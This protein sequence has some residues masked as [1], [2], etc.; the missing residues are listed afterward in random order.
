MTRRGDR[1]AAHAEPYAPHRRTAVLFAGVGTAGVYHAGVLRALHEAGVKIDVVAGRGIGAVTALFAAVDGSARLWDS[2]G[3]WHAPV[4]PQLYPWHPWLR[5]FGWAS[6]LAVFLVV[7]PIAAIV[8]G[9]IVFPIDFVLRML[10]WSGQGLTEGYVSVV[11]AAFGPT[12]FPTW[13]PRFVVLALGG[14]LALVAASAVV[15]TAR[16]RERGPL[17]W[18]MVPAPLTAERT[19]EHCWTAIWDLVR[20]AANIRQPSSSELATRYAELLSENLGQPGFRELVIS[21]HDLDARRD[22]VCTVVADMRRRGL[23]ARPTQAEVDARHTEVVDLTALGRDRLGDI[24]AAALTVPLATAWHDMTL[25]TD[26]YWRGETHRLTD[27]PGSL[28]RLVCELVDLDVEQVLLVSAAP[29]RP[30][31]HELIPPRLDGRARMGEYVQAAEVAALHDVLTAGRSGGVRLFVIH[32]E[33]NPVGPFDFD[34]AFD[35]RS[36]RPYSLTE[37]MARG[38]ED[39]YKQFVE[40]LVAPSGDR[41][42]HRAT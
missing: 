26:G 1:S 10:G 32:P 15:R 28:Q 35:D 30:A 24:V 8:A 12:G 22:L 38:Y 14:A 21:V 9:L 40:A 6:A 4:V 7:F 3:F 16:R 41:V 25:P 19:V 5:L 29:E 20:G 42:G 13:L 17:W 18:R 27:R 23:M 37:L 36:D 2:R 31:V 11:A 34:G 33:H 39:A